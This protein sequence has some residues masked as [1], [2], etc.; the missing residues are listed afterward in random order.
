MLLEGGGWGFE[1]WQ[2]VMIASSI[3]YNIAIFWQ[4]VRRLEPA[5]QAQKLLYIPAIGIHIGVENYGYNQKAVRRR[6]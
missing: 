6:L 2:W 1:R 3:G 4:H 5:L